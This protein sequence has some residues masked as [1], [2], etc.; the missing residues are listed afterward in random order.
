MFFTVHFW[1]FLITEKGYF[2][3]FLTS[4]G[5]TLLTCYLIWSAI[6][7]SIRFIQQFT[8]ACT[9]YRLRQ[10]NIDEQFDNLPSKPAGCCFPHN[11]LQWYEY[12]QWVLFILGVE[13]AVCITGLYW[14]LFSPIVKPSVLFE[15]SNFAAHLINGIVG[16]VEV[17]VTRLPVRIYH[18]IYLL[19]LCSVY[20][21]FTG[22]YFAAGGGNPFDNGTYIYPQL[23]YGTDPG[24]SAALA[25]SAALVY[26]PFIHLFFY[27]NYLMREGLL[28]LL[29]KYRNS[30]SL[31]YQVFNDSD[32]TERNS[33][34][35]SDSL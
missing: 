30:R 25:L 16:L 34:I 4:W 27:F 8:S 3:I 24:S 26:V 21:V 23:D 15:Y 1:W 35:R 32:E 6:S 19:F 18:F 17:W 5:Y 10:Q 11:S 22:V 12:I 31:N 13:L 33:L 2:F 28:Y 7:V 29:C 14:P 9:S 20:L